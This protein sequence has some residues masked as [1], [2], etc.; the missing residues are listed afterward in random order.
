MK[1]A[2]IQ[3]SKNVC[4]QKIKQVCMQLGITFI[5]AAVIFEFG[6]QHWQIIED[7]LDE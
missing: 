1:I 7:A 2:C 3:T 4:M 5:Y 6:N